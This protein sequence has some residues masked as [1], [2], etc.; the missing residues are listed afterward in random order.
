MERIKIGSNKK[1]IRNDLAKKNMTFSQESCQAIIEMGNVEL[2]ELKTSRVRCPSCPHHVFEGTITCSCGKD[3]RSNQEMTQRMK[4]A[5]EVLKMPF[6]RAYHPNSRGC[7][8]GSQLWQQHHHKANDALRAATR[9]NDKTFVIF[10]WIDGKTLWNTENL[11]K[12]LVGTMR[13]YDI[14]TTSY[15][16]KSLT[17]RLLN[18]EADATIWCI[19]V[20]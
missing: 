18:N 10:L 2:I 15:R 5:F 6:L 19:H 1:C 7:K 9:K 12:P 14:S 20:V 17:K 13:L 4:K 8:H 16:F 11:T 3:I